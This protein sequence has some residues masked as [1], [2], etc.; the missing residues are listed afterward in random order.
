M[1]ANT[2]CPHCGRK[3]VLTSPEKRDAETR[4]WYYYE[5]L[6]LTPMYPGQFSDLKKVELQCAK[7]KTTWE[8]LHALRTDLRA[9]KETV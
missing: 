9:Q 7:C 4:G 3:L 8:S 5:L 6:V 2:I 1:N